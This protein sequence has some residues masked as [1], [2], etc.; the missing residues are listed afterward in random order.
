[1]PYQTANGIQL[2]YEWHGL[3]DGFPVVLVNGLLMDTTSWVFQL[4]A[5][6]Q[7][8]R[9]LLYDC[10]G[11]GRSDKPPGPYPQALHAQD[12][13]ALL[14]ALDVEQAHFVGLSN[15]G[16]VTMHFI[17]DHPQRGAR[18]VLV[19]TF[20]YAD[21]LM[22]SKLDSWLAAVEAGGLLLRFDVATPWI[23]SRNFMSNQPAILAALRTKAEQADP[24]AG[25]ALITGTLEY[26][27]RDRLPRIPAPTLVLVGEEDV[28]TPPWYARQL[29]EN[30]PNAQLAIIPGAG[31]ALTIERPT[32]FNMMA[33]AFLQETAA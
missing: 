14:D 15:G 16:T 6:A 13:L 21:A 26:D 22:R 25:H 33:L 23:W 29:A 7:H 2:Y 20:A 32:I 17:S 19:D 12:L 10:R 28:L 5:F 8:F 3:E 4:P 1:M 24:A 18:L 27:I 30:I 11:Q 9:V 31:H